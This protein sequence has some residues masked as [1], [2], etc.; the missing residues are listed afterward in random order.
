MREVQTFKSKSITIHSDP[1][2]SIDADGEYIGSTPLELAIAPQQIQVLVWN[3][4]M[5]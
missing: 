4:L 2:V 3:K 1:P 5:M